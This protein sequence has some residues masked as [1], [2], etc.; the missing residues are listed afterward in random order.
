MNIVW[1]YFY[2]K[3]LSLHYKKNVPKVFIIP[4]FFFVKYILDH[5]P[6][7]KNLPVCRAAELENIPVP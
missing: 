5:T 4:T 2:M 1:G 3:L 7:R 6:R